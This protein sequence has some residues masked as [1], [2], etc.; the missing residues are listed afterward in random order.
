MKLNIETYLATEHLPGGPIYLWETEDC[1]AGAD[2][3]DDGRPA[4]LGQKIAYVITVILV[5]AMMIWMSTLTS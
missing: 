4:T 5:V 1:Y 3:Y 2:C